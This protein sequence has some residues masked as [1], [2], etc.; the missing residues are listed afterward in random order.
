[1][2]GEERGGQGREA[3]EWMGGRLGQ[4]LI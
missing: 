4:E 2:G 3:R 1:M